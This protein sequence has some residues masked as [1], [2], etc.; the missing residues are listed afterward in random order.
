M[1]T[2]AVGGSFTWASLLCRF[3]R[4]IDPFA[5]ADTNAVDAEML[6]LQAG[7]GADEWAD[8]DMP[9]PLPDIHDREVAFALMHESLHYW[10]LISSPMMQSL[11]ITALQKVRLVTRLNGGDV[12]FVCGHP[13]FESDQAGT[14]AALAAAE[15]LMGGARADRVTGLEVRK[16]V[17]LIPDPATTIA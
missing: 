5:T 12:N 1:A 6:A 11:V 10:Q 13:D 7:F 8:L 2:E 3:T 14:T 9:E 4:D 17:E 16:Q 15:A